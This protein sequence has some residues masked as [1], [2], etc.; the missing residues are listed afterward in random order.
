MT[1]THPTEAGKGAQAVQTNGIGQ[2]TTAHLNLTTTMAAQITAE[3]AQTER[4]CTMSKER[5]ERG[6]RQ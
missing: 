6:A 1:I 2:P 4:F 5:R 3:A